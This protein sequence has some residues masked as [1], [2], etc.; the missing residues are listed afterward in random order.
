MSKN[1][2]ETPA[3]ELGMTAKELVMSRL[4][5]LADMMSEGKRIQDTNMTRAFIAAVS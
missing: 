1:Y 2:Y 5:K 4:Q 3:S